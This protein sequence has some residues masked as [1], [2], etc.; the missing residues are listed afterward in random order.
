MD[1]VG[2]MDHPMPQQL[3]HPTAHPMD[4]HSPP[5][6]LDA[7]TAAGQD[8]VAGRPS[9]EVVERDTRAWVERAVIGLNLCPFARAVQ[10]KGR[11]HYAVSAAGDASSLLADLAREIEALVAC[12]PSVRETTLLIAP[13]CLA[14]FLAFNDFLGRADRLLRKLRCEGV[15]Q[16]ASFHPD[17]RFAGTAADDITNA[18]NRS[19]YPTLHLLREDS[20]DVA[21]QAFPEA[22][23]IFERNQRTL[24]QLGAA[25]WA[26]LDVGRSDHE[27]PAG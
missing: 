2:Q 3:A 6:R 8:Q 5:D 18:T 4:Q 24:E 15:L 17:Y 25:G 12:D 27:A 19:P 26:A 16:I 20:I 13:G 1:N 10:V 14:D 11:L 23:Q 7:A 22:A 9:S 21:V